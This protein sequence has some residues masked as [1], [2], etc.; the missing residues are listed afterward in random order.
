MEAPQS[1]L[2]VDDD[3]DIRTLV[4]DHLRDAGYQAH[5]AANGAE[6]WKTLER[7]GGVDLIILDINMPGED[8]L[9]LCRRIR[10][11]GQTPVIMLTAR[12]EPIDR[13]LGLELGADDYLAKPFEP[14]EL[15]ARIK[16][17]L[18][19]AQ[20][21]PANLEPLKATSARFS[22]WRLDMERRHLEDPGKR[23]VMLSGA[24]FR[25]LCIF[26]EHANRVLTRDQLVTLSG[27]SP[28]ENLD[29]SIDLQVSRLRRKLGDSDLIKTVRNEGYVFAT[30]VDFV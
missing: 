13:I 8:G 5:T 20:A 10:D 16:S 2:V 25:M 6:M 27:G 4:A 19:R 22:G 30:P 28:S 29:R 11:Q 26:L 9:T 14:R 18:R 3:R 17:V 7:L 12:G 24:E 21:L 15:S 23:I 1:I